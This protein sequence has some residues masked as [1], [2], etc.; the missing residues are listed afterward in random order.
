MRTPWTLDSSDGNGEKT[1]YIWVKDL[2]GNISQTPYE[3]KMKL[4]TKLI[5]GEANKVEIYFA[6]YD[7]NLA[8]DK[9]RLVEGNVNVQVAGEAVQPGNKQVL[10]EDENFEY[11]GMSAIKYKTTLTNVKGVGRL[12]LAIDSGTL[13]DKVGNVN[14]KKVLETD[15]YI[16]TNKPTISVDAS[17]NVTI[18]DAEGNLAAVTVNGVLRTTGG[19]SI[20]TVNSGDVIKAYDLAGNVTSKTI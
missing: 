14:A 19:G 9:S 5:G 10:K 3:A 7:R 1:V 2:A 6:G 18:T 11:N 15:Y 4:N 17:G 20:G 8:K 12:D 13:Q 16:D